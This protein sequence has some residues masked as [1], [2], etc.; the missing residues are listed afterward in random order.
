MG[1]LERYTLVSA[2]ARKV[3]MKNGNEEVRSVS[4]YGKCRKDSLQTTK[5]TKCPNPN[6][7]SCQHP[8]TFRVHSQG[9]QAF[10]LVAPFQL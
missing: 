9:P 1:E 3:E 8:L 2:T 4:V 7:K 6:R 5:M 10:S